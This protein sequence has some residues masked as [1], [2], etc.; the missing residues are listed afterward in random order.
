MQKYYSL[1]PL[2]LEHI[3]EHVPQVHTS[4]SGEKQSLFLGKQLVSE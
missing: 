3:M 4:V 1:V 2:P